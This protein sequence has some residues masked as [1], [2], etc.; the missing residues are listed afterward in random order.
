M[1]TRSKVYIKCEK[2][3]KNT[4]PLNNCGMRI[5]YILMKMNSVDQNRD[6]D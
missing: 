4:I 2:K 5:Q 1:T 3:V 6:V